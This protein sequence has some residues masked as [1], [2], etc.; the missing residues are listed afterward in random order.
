MPIK[1]ITARNID[2]E[3]GVY[4][5]TGDST[6]T[7]EGIIEEPNGQR[8]TMLFEVEGVKD[9]YDAIQTVNFYYCGYFDKTTVRNIQQ[10]A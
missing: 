8:I 6:F 5:T 7:F 10:I 4:V 1:K 2:G 3:N 9:S